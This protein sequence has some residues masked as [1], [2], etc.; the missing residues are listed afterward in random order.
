MQAK[1]KAPFQL[2]NVWMMDRDWNVVLSERTHIYIDGSSLTGYNF[3]R[4]AHRVPVPITEEMRFGRRPVSMLNRTRAIAVHNPPRPLPTQFVCGA[5]ISSLLAQSTEAKV[6]L[7]HGYCAGQNEFPPSHFDNAV[8][9]QDHKQ[10]RSNDAFAL[11]IKEFGDQF[12][13]FTIV[14][15]SSSPWSATNVLI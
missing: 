14:C 13:A 5:E 8:A 12:P 2:R 3:V 4:S 1:A 7:V 9:F 15:T 10:S 6:I 11:K